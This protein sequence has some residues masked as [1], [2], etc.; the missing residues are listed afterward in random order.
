MVFKN[1][2]FFLQFIVGQSEICMNITM[3]RMIFET[4]RDVLKTS[5]DEFKSIQTTELPKL[6]E[7]EE[8][9]EITAKVHGLIHNAEKYR[10]NSEQQFCF[11]DLYNN[12]FW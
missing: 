7:C 6:K 1:K 5:V 11:I 3:R 8:F 12:R 10:T 2:H 9:D 4:D